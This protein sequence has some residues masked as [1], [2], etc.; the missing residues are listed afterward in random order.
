MEFKVGDKVVGTR[1]IDDRIFEF[2]YELSELRMAVISKDGAA[3]GLNQLRH[4][5]AEEIKAGRRLITSNSRELETVGDD[6]H[7]ENHISPHCR[8]NCFQDDTTMGTRTVDIEAENERL[9]TENIAMQAEIDR[10]KNDLNHMEACYIE[11]KKMC[12]VLA[13]GVGL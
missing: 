6:T 5:T 11:K 12:D 10:L 3:I 1:L 7:I 4:A 2:Q 8:I 9:K 13:I